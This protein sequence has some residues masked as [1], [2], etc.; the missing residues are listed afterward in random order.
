M[1]HSGS[2]PNKLSQ[3]QSED[4]LLLDNYNKCRTDKTFRSLYQST[5]RKNLFRTS[6][7]E[8][9]KNVQLNCRKK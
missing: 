9:K 1:E 3:S 6:E 5:L 2:Q 7:S 8:I 4:H